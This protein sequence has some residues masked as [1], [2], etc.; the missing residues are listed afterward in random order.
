MKSKGHL[1]IYI[2]QV[3]VND[4]IKNYI[5]KCLLQHV[6]EE[7]HIPKTIIVFGAG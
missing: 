1:Y 7:L 3:F 4:Q 2:Q 5:N 6:E